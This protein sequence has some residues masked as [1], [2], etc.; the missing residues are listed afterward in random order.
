MV[1]LCPTSE[2]ESERERESEGERKAREREGERARKKDRGRE[3][4]GGRETERERERDREE[5]E[6]CRDRERDMMR[7]S[8]DCAW[9]GFE[10]VRFLWLCVDKN[11]NTHHVKTHA[12]SFTFCYSNAETHTQYTNKTTTKQ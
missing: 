3:R 1:S 5:R 7:I 10:S 12:L 6:G 8:Y 4:K 11:L 9:M 2:R